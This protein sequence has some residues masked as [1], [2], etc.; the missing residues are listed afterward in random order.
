MDILNKIS[1]QGYMPYNFTDLILVE[2]YNKLCDIENKLDKAKTIN[3]F[4]PVN[5]QE[6]PAEVVPETNPAE[7]EQVKPKPVKKKT[8]K[9]KSTAKKGKV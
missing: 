3:P 6:T 4:E 2:I 1:E 7:K 9:K 5:A 8:A